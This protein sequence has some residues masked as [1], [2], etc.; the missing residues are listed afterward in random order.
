MIVIF[1]K[2]KYFTTL[3]VSLSVDERYSHPLQCTAQLLYCIVQ[4]PPCKIQAKRFGELN[5]VSCVLSMF[6]PKAYYLHI[7]D[8]A[9]FSILS[10]IH[11]CICSHFGIALILCIFNLNKHL[12]GCHEEVLAQV[13]GRCILHNFPHCFE[14]QPECKFS[15]N[16][17][18]ALSLE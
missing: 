2:Y 17:F 6:P 7:V 14:S 3:C 4:W 16:K 1:L 11:F 13:V 12:H 8:R 9:A 18:M 5:P 10:N 15:C